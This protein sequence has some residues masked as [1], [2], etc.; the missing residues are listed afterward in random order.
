MTTFYGL[1]S[2]FA[3]CTKQLR[4]WE[5]ILETIWIY[6]CWNLEMACN[7]FSLKSR[8]VRT[9]PHKR[10]RWSLTL[11][12]TTSCKWPLTLRILGG[13]P[14][15]VWLHL[16]ITVVVVSYITFLI[17]YLHVHSLGWRT[18]HFVSQSYGYY[19]WI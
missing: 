9:C 1:I 7:A 6:L 15:E 3:E 12:A 19:W 16:F 10:I 5:E 8:C 2:V 13:R 17:I 14:Q 4:V 18:S 11:I